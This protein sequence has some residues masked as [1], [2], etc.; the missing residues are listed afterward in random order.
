MAC[1][2]IV[3]SPRLGRTQRDK[4]KVAA[5]KAIIAW[6]MAPAMEAGQTQRRAGNNGRR[7]QQMLKRKKNLSSSSMVP[8]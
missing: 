6:A 1:E 4:A 5:P 8:S 3:T 2:E 7:V